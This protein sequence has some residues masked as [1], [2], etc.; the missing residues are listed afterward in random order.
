MEDS[1]A[2]PLSLS[3]G[4]DGADLTQRFEAGSWPGCGSDL[5]MFSI[6]DSYEDQRK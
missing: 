4:N 3:A 1:G 5:R 2:R 6:L